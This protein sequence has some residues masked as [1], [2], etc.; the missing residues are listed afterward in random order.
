MANYTISHGAPA[1]PA[2]AEPTPG[3]S[4]RAPLSPFLL[5]DHILPPGPIHGRLLHLSFPCLRGPSTRPPRPPAGDL[6][7][8]GRQ[9]V[10]RL[11]LDRELDLELELES[12]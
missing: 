5:P 11:R 2:V 9:S 4:V 8:K 6:R 7:P 12:I 1:A 3:A 10:L